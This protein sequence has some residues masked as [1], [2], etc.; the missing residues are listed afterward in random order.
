VSLTSDDINK[1][2]L[3][4]RLA[5]GD[6]EMEDVRRKLTDIVALVDELQA[7]DTAGVEPLAHPL[8]QPQRLR[9]DIVTETDEHERFQSNAPSVEQGL[10]LVP[11]V[12]E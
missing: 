8:E 10:Y 5:I 6:G 3:L 1:L 9:E 7:V 12:I 11:K 4:A 2:C